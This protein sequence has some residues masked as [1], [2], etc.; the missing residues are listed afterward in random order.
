MNPVLCQPARGQPPYPPS[1]GDALD[2]GVTVAGSV[3][4]AA[5]SRDKCAAGIALPPQAAHR[6]AIHAISMVK[7]GCLDRFIKAREA[8]AHVSR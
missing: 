4:S 1:D 2:A 7:K 6:R 3:G 5:G 8:D